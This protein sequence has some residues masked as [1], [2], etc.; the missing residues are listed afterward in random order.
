MFTGSIT[1]MVT[2]MR[3]GG[4]DWAGFQS[5][6]EQ[7][8]AGGT[9]GIVVCGTTG[10][11]ATLTEEEWK[12]AISTA[13]DVVA[14]R[15]PV[16]AGA[17]S[18]STSHSIERADFAKREGAQ[19]ILVV[20]PY[21]NRPGQEGLLAHYRAIADAVA[22]PMVLYNVPGRT[23]IDMSAATVATL[24]EHPNVVGVKDATADMGRMSRHAIDCREGFVFLS[25]DDASAL[26]FNAHG[27]H[28]AISV[29]S[30]IAP[31]MCAQFQRATRDGE[32]AKA[33]ALH[34]NLM[35]WHQL[36]F[37]SPSPGP[38]KYVLS[39]LGLISKELRLPL[40]SPPTPVIEALELALQSMPPE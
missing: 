21:Y 6:L 33:R 27:G 9:E 2:P 16:I 18:Y 12:R 7:Q 39:R 1:A 40:V 38:V 26:G 3:Q 11:V 8:I 23:G 15:I 31:R 10:E 35:V 14:G 29:T 34:E 30:N 20:T 36:L 24:S 4:V 37:S 5:M 25:G 22:I 19:G 13:I 17:G 28:G 32:W